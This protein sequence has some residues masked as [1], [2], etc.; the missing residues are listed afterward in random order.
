MILFLLLYW[1]TDT[2]VILIPFNIDYM[3]SKDLYYNY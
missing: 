1:D 2:F 3:C